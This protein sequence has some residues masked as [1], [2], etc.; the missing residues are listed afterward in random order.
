MGIMGI[1]GIMLNMLRTGQMFSGLKW[2]YDL[3]SG[4]PGYLDYST[5]VYSGVL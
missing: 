4:V 1:M 5:L 3:T 2:E